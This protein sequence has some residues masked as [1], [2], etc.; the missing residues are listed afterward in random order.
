MTATKKLTTSSV[1]AQRQA[2]TEAAHWYALLC[3]EDVSHKDKTDWQAWLNPELNCE[4]NQWAWQRVERL[5]NNLSQ[6]PTALTVNSLAKVDE[7]FNQE[8][9]MAMRSLMVIFGTGSLGWL[10]YRADITSITDLVLAEQRSKTGQVR[11]LALPDGSQVILNTASAIDINFST[12]ERRIVLHQGEIMVETAKAAFNSLEARPFIVET[13]HGSIQALGTR[14]SVRKFDHEIQVNVYQHSVRVTTNTG[15]QQLCSVSQSLNF[16]VSDISNLKENTISDA[17]TEHMLV[18]TDMPLTDFINEVSRY[19]PGFLRC[20][21]SL[22]KHRISGAFNTQD[23]EQILRA[24]EK[25]FP[26][27][28]NRFSRY[29]VNVSPLL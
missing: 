11:T 18:V 13:A 21:A 22:A 14:F 6:M 3:A 4:L 20:H 10:G 15:K 28:I 17:W 9:R 23:T 7:H 1:A 26:L 25:S 2:L 8:R 5:Q 24:L 27:K 19:R 16:T 29:W 12:T